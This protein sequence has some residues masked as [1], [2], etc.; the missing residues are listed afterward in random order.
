MEVTKS[1][2]QNIIVLYLDPT[3]QGSFSGL[4]K[5]RSA[6]KKYKNINISKKNLQ[7]ILLSIP[8]YQQF[9][10]RNVNSTPKFK[11]FNNIN[12]AREVWARRDFFSQMMSTYFFETTPYSFG[13]QFSS[14]DVSKLCISNSP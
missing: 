13:L 11:S 4:E 9:A 6:L 5:F 10:P 7:N 1:L 8:A 3:F 12:G 2:R 14:I